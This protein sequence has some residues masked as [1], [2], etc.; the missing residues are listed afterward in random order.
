MNELNRNTRRNKA[1][2]GFTLIELMIVVA[3]IGIL[4]AIAIPRY[5]DYVARSQVSEVILAAS[6]CRTAIS[7]TSQTGLATA[8]DAANSF[9]CEVFGEDA[10]VSQ[11]VNT[12]T[13]DVNGVITV[14]AQNI[15]GLTAGTADTITL[16]PHHTVPPRASGTAMVAADFL[17]TSDNVI[18][19]WVCD[20]TIPE[21]SR[22]NSCRGI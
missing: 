18:R 12:V 5:Q 8:P 1:Q 3:I 2:G 19:T 11:F 15:R 21:N 7:E 9:G 6:V 22:P 17:A 20:G 14:T 13:T 10:P 4:A 16:T